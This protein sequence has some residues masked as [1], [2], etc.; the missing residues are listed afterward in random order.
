MV[1]AANVREWSLRLAGR[2]WHRLTVC[3]IILT[4]MAVSREVLGEYAEATAEPRVDMFLRSSVAR[5]HERD[6]V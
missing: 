3:G 1:V 4:T 6:Y 2:L 5:R